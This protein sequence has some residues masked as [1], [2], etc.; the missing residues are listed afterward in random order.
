M[1]GTVLSLQGALFSERCMCWELMWALPLH[2][3]TKMYYS[4][5]IES[6]MRM[7]IDK[8]LKPETYVWRKCAVIFQILKSRSVLMQSRKPLTKITS[9]RWCKH[10]NEC[11]EL[12]YVLVRMSKSRCA[13]KRQTIN[14]KSIKNY[15]IMLFHTKDCSC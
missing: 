5:L 2:W 10:T 12:S 3:M 14:N 4:D 6:I 13:A 1:N 11:V 9:T 7:E 8:R 15:C